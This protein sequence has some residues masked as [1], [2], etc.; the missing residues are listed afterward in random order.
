M[1]VS[2]L[3]LL[4]SATALSLV[5]GAKA[6]RV[7]GNDTAAPT[8]YTWRIGEAKYDGP[9]PS[10]QNGLGTVAISI[11]SS[12]S[13]AVF[14]CITQWP[15]SWA[16]WYEG[17]SN[18]VWGDCIWTASG[19]MYDKTISFAVDW[20]NGTMYLSHTFPCTNRPG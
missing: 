6:A 11:T 14:E 19:P 18:I 7:C 17:G 20:K 12:P 9:K 16:G 2:S 1:V 10:S 5:S 4:V 15:E 8:T 3:L 13:R